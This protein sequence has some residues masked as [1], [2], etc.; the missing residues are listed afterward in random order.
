[1]DGLLGQR[2]VP[3]KAFCQFLSDFFTIFGKFEAAIPDGCQAQTV[4]FKNETVLKIA[5]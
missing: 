1:M 3:A 5:H 2:D 4:D